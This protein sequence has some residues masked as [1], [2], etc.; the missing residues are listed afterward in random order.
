M[1]PIYPQFQNSGSTAAT[2]DYYHGYRLFEKNAKP[3]RY[4]FG[5]G[6]SYTT[7]SLQQ[8]ASALFKLDDPGNR[9]PER[10]GHSREQR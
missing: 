1:K 7:F 10:S 5:Y 6:L 2:I 3:V 4:W 8:S 9:R